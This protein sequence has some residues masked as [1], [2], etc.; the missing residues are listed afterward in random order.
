VKAEKARRR[1]YEFVV[2]AW[3][4]LEPSTPFRDGLHVGAICEHV[5]A[6]T[7]GR[8]QHLIINVPPGHAKSLLAAVFWPAWVWISHPE[9]RWLFS[10]YRE[11]LDTRDS[12]RCRRLIESGWYQERWGDRFQ[13]A[14]DQN[15]KNRFENTESGYR[16]VV[17]KGSGTGERGDYVVVDDPH[18]V[19]QA[20]S[21]G[22]RQGAIEWW[23]GSM[24][25]R[26]NDLSTGH[27]VVIQQRLHEADLTGDLLEKGGYELLCLPAEFD[28]ER[29]CTTAIG[30]TDPRQESG[31]LLWPEMLTRDVLQ[32]QKVTLG[33]YRYAGQYQQ[34]PSPAEGG[35][36][37]RGWWGY[38]RPADRELPPVQV[39]M[40]DGAMRTI[41]PVP[42]PERFDQVI[43]SWDLSFKGGTTSDFIAG[44]VWGARK[45][46]R[47]LLDQRRDRLNMPQT[48]EAI[49]ALSAKWPEAA[50]K[51]VEDKANGP[52]V[53]AFLQHELSGLV[54]VN[55]EGGKLARAQ[56]VSPQ[57][58]SG[59]VYLPHPAMAPWVE[60][61]IEEC[62]AF[63]NG[64]HDDQVDQMTQALNRL[65]SCGAIYPLH[66]SEISVEPFKIPDDWPRAY[67]MQV[68]LEE[69]AVLW[70]AKDPA[71]GKI[72]FYAEHYY[73]HT[74]ASQNACA[75]KTPGAWIPGVL[76]AGYVGRSQTDSDQLLQM[77]R[78]LGLDLSLAADTEESGI[79]ETRQLL[80]TNRLKVFKSLANFFTEYRVYRRDEKGRLGRGNEHLLA[81]CHA[82]VVC[83]PSRIRTKPLQTSGYYYAPSTHV[84]A[85]DRS[86]MV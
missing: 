59:N 17:P 28:V 41:V 54:A 66:D 6:V 13:L 43:Q 33:S 21:D 24:S 62:A 67:G 72:F 5:Q 51:L 53:V 15:E 36:F 32:H 23:N 4:V 38:W 64:R 86:W 57:V 11:P 71:S 12:V 56:A 68:S 70:G 48:V 52:A 3:H 77:Y 34:R 42:L 10:S 50:L 35:I 73:R 63:P 18:S 30:W 46:D 79:H 74:D 20:E 83:G 26:L 27:K 80:V 31:E 84:P 39:R 25:T 16:I 81:C 76:A 65:L 14:A 9:T 55:P 8:L 19:D 60:G 44:G 61:F 7:E 49:R 47:Y 69:T 78:K 75:I 22:E 82:L 29:R 37:K 40:P 2:Q 58:E 45:A 1:L 85:G